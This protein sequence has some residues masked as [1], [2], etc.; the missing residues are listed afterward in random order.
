MIRHATFLDRDAI[1]AFVKE[2]YPQTHY[3][4]QA[5]FDDE[6][7]TELTEFLIRTGIVLLATEEENIIGILGAGIRPHVFNK[8]VLSCHEFIWY[9]TPEHQKSGLGV[10]LIERADNLR[11]LRGCVSFQMMR[12]DNSSPYLDKVFLPLG[13]EPS[14]HCW[15]KVN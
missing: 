11:Q 12:L 14:E 1:V 5:E 10:A 8:S 3:A 7:V 9:V 2:F 13:F 6:T 15:T 4:K